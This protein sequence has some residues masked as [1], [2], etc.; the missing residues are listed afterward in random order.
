LLKISLPVA[1]G[2]DSKFINAGNIQNRGF[3]AI[4]NIKPVDAQLKWDI[5]INYAT[6]KNVVA[7]LSEGLTEYTIR[8]RSWMTTFKAVEGGEYGDI[9]TRGFVRNE[10]GR[11]LINYLGTPICTDGQTALMGNYNPDWIGGIRNSFRFKGFDFSFMID[12]RI[13][14][15]VFS[16]TEANLA[17]EGF[18]DYT[19]KGRDGMVVDGVIQTLDWEGNVI[20]EIE[21]NILTTSESYWQSLGGRNSPVGEAFRYDGSNI[22]MREA[23]LGYTKSFNG[24]I[25][26][27]INV[28]LVGRNLFFIMNRAK[29]LDPNL[30]PG[31]SNYQGVE[32]FGLPGTRSIGMNLKVTF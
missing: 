25:L 6:N 7:E 14:G 2:Y 27:N 17:A 19:L 4:L 1:S 9:Y 22:R 30:M 20:S 5:A 18:A 29:I 24:R 3:E 12:I 8:E 32:S 11:I 10:D 21:N 16:Y 15:D 13:G 28:S 26:R 31:N 23:V